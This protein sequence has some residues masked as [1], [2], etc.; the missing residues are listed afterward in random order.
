[1]K[2]FKDLENDTA[3]MSKEEYLA[4]FPKQVIKEGKIIPIREELEKRFRETGKLDLQKL[5][6]GEPIEIESPVSEALARGESVEASSI[7]TLRVRT[8]TGKRNLILKL[9]NEDKIS[10]AYALLKPYTEGKNVQFTLRT[11]F[12]SRSYEVAESKSLKELGLAPA[13]AMI[14]QA[15]IKK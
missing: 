15:L 4:Q 3:P 5:N 12:P 1:M 13:S 10:L 6:S 7:V 8:E 9:R 11:N 2:D 14:I